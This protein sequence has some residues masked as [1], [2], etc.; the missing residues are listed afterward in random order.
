MEEP[1]KNAALGLAAQAEKNEIVAREQGIDDL[2]DD[3]VFIAMHAGKKC[4]AFFDGAEQI[5]TELILD[6]A[7]NAAWI[8]IRDALELAEC[9][10][11][12]MS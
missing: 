8:K 7:R 1:A 4:F 11:F 6:G 2:R 10:W 9:P 3:S 12:R 5:A